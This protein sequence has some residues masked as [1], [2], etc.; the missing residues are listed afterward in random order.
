VIAVLSAGL[1]AANAQTPVTT[2][3]T[4]V[5]IPFENRSN[6]PGLEWIS[7]SFPELLGERLN[8]PSIFVAGR[9][10]RLRAYDRL[11]IPTALRVS[12]ATA[13]R[14]AEEMDVD[15]MVLGSFTFDGRTFTATAQLL[16][17]QRLHLLPVV[18][19]SGPLPQLIDIQ[20]ALA[21]DLLQSMRLALAPN[22]T[23][24]LA[25]APSIRLDAFENY[26][27]G[28]ITT[29]PQDKVRRLREAVRL[30]PDY[31]E[32][33]LALGKEYFR[34]RQFDQAAATL[35][36]VPPANPLAREANFYLGL[37]EFYQGDFARAETAFAF[38]AAR[39]PLGEV[40]NN[41]G[42][43]EARRGERSA[44]EHF[45]KAIQTD[46][47]EA[48]YQF[49]LAITLY[50]SGDAAGASKHLHEALTLRPTDAEAKAF[51]DQISAQAGHTKAP[52]ERIRR[53]Y[54]ENSFRQLAL[55]LNAAAEE[56]L[57]N[58]DPRTHA[59][60]HADRGHEL[61]AQGFMTEAEKE[62]REAISLDGNNPDAHAGLAQVLENN[63][64][65]NAA[66]T[67]A[68]T[69]LRLRQFAEPL[70]VLAQLDLRDNKLDSASA[71][72][73]RALALEP[74]NTQA[75]DL[76]RAIAAK[77]AGKAQPLPNQ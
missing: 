30:L 62:F 77:L 24:F 26:V 71:N 27:R 13:Y 4:I 66:R 3:Q 9:E 54:E 29:V 60:F 15:Y 76:K 52:L 31:P 32:A 49:N 56:K 8:S 46:P 5:V 18:T 55:K 23:A 58:T 57:A 41:L 17:M 2:G 51:L 44:S 53:N 35:S 19:E 38:V 14:V 64:D 11:G 59:V 45:E 47:G 37:S 34:E 75:Q 21:W 68:E 1:G 69:A 16:D 20:T 43:A 50:R 65:V 36:R 72:V 33:L 73:D 39:L 48:D 22:R 70:L 7:E 74:A 28:S 40:Y 63:G 10:D 12:R 42:V 67:E 61:L 25:A 6:A